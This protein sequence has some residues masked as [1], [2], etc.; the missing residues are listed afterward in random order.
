M[1]LFTFG[2]RLTV[3]KTTIVKEFEVQKKFFNLVQFPKKLVLFTAGRPV[4]VV[5]TTI[6]SEFD[7]PRKNSNRQFS[8]VSQ[9]VGLISCWQ[10]C[11]SS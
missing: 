3:V 1:V 10:T 7:V 8:S 5:K 2:G 11:F 4:L 6:V 9:K